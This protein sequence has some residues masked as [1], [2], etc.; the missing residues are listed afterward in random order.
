GRF[1][2]LSRGFHSPEAER[3]DARAR[4][5]RVGGRRFSTAKLVIHLF[6]SQSF[7]SS[8]GGAGNSPVLVIPAQAGI[9]FLLW[10]LC[11]EQSFH[12]SCGGAGNFLCWCKESHQRN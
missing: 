3:L 8:C 10:L 7:H 11:S 12:S 9:Q 1:L 2:S 5:S 6:Q 4:H